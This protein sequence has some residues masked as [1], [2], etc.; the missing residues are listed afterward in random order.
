MAA[1]GLSKHRQRPYRLRPRAIEPCIA[2]DSSEEFGGG[3][4]RLGRPEE[5]AGVRPQ[6]IVEEPHELLLQTAFQVDQKVPA[7]NEV[8]PQKRRVPELCDAKSTMSRSSVRTR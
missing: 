3:F 2:V 8:E 1:R 5:Q 6:P 4:D 7:G